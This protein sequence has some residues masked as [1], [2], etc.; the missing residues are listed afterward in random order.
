MSGSGDRLPSGTGFLFLGKEGLWL[1]E[2]RKTDARGVKIY[3][4]EGTRV[5]REGRNPGPKCFRS[6]C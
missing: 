4:V 3:K 2:K 5:S 6:R 1:S